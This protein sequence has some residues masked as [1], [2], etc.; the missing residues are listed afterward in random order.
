M[1][2]TKLSIHTLVIFALI[3]AIALETWT[4]LRL[5]AVVTRGAAVV[6]VD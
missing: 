5:C 6:C 3:G 1:G 2:E 4:L